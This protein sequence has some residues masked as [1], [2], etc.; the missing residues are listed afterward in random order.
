MEVGIPLRTPCFVVASLQLSIY[1]ENKAND[2]QVVVSR[3]ESK[4][5]SA[6][7]NQQMLRSLREGLGGAVAVLGTDST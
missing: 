5:S 3:V 2:F 7:L 1:L 4:K 6:S